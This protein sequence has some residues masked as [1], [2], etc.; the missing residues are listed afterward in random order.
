MNFTITTALELIAALPA[1]I[2]GIMSLMAEAQAAFGKG[3]GTEKKTAVLASVSAV[4]TD[5]T[6]WKQFQ[7]FFSTLVDFFVIFKKKDTAS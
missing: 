1:I 3:T 5:E 6:L 7:G 4:I 2:K